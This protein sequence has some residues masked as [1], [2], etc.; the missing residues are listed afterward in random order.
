MLVVGKTHRVRPQ[1]REQIEVLILIGA[2]NGPSLDRA[3]LVHCSTPQG[4]VPAVQKESSVGIELHGPQPQRL[5]DPVE[6]LATRGAQSHDDPIQVG[7]FPSLPQMRV[8]DA[9][10]RPHRRDRSRRNGERLRVCD[11]V[12]SGGILDMSLH[13]NPPRSLPIVRDSA[14]H[15]HGG[16]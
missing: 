7:V 15:L 3:I 1:I 14:G 6:H 9:E 10:A 11:Q 16:S 12:G 2:S 8:L 4:H 13:A 5:T